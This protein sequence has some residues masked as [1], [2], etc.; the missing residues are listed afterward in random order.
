[1]TELAL[2]DVRTR[3]TW[4]AWLAKHHTSSR[5]VGLVFHKAQTGVKLLPYEDFVREARS[6]GWIDSLVKRL[7]DARSRPLIEGR[8]DEL[9]A[10]VAHD[11][12]WPAASARPAPVGR[13]ID[14]RPDPVGTA[15]GQRVAQKVHAPAFVRARGHQRRHAGMSYAP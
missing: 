3:A 5:G 15:V 1:M 4:R 12:L 10:V 9:R 8:A 6:F 14:E 7:D 2:L 13:V 11:R